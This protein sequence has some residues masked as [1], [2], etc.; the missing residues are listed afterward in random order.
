MPRS[1]DVRTR[2]GHRIR[3]LRLERNLTLEKI[4][5]RAGLSGKYVQAIE[6]ARQAPTIDT[7]AKLARALGVPP[8]E[9]LDVDERT[10]RALR[11]RASE[12]IAAA[13]DDE[14]MRI[15]RVLE[16]MLD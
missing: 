9:L 3:Q 10:P 15:V 14:L 5:E 12:L 8:R 11:A 7:I 2:F 4:G 16:L 1:S 6:M 13:T